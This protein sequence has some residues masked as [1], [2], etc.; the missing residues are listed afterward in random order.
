[1]TSA[2]LTFTTDTFRPQVSV[3]PSSVMTFVFTKSGDRPVS[4]MTGTEI[5]YNKIETLAT[6]NPAFGT[7]YQISGQT[8]TFYNST[9]LFIINWF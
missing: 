1:M 2:P 7:A 9:P 6:T 5:H 8:V 4:N 3:A